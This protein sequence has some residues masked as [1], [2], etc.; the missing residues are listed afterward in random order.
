MQISSD[1]KLKQGTKLT[2]D[3]KLYI[4]LSCID[5]SWLK[6]AEMGGYIVTISEV[7]NAN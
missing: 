4:V 2:K 1:K 7:G 6:G 5:L 3:G